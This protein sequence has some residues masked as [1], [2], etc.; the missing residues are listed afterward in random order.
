[1]KLKNVT[2]RT[3]IYVLSASLILPQW[4]MHAQ[5]APADDFKTSFFDLF[6]EDSDSKNKDQNKDGKTDSTKKDD[7]G[8]F[9]T[10]PNLGGG[11]NNG[12]TKTGTP[13]N[14][15]GNRQGNNNSS[16][17]SGNTMKSAKLAAPYNCPLFENRPHKE[18]IDAITQLSTA[19]NVSPECENNNSVKSIEENAKALKD[20]MTALSGTLDADPA[21]FTATGFDANVTAALTA[22]NNLG[23]ILN[24]NAFLNSSCGRQAMSSGKALLAFNDM[25]NGFA[26]Y[27]LFA[28]AAN[29]ALAPALPFV[30]GGTVVTTGISV[31]SKM[32]DQKTLDMVKPEHRDAVL[33]NT[34]QYV[35]VAK[36]VRF[37]QLAQSGKIEKISQELEQKIT[38]YK[39][40]FSRPSTELTS[41]LAYRQ[42]ASVSFSNMDKQV[43]DDKT[44]LAAVNAQL[45]ANSDDLMVCTMARELVNWAQDGK[46]FPSSAFNN[47][48]QV[49]MQGDRP[50][51]L[52]SVTLKSLNAASMKRIVEAADLAPTDETALK[53]CAQAGKTWITGIN[54][55]VMLTEKTLI[56]NKVALENELAQ[57]LEYRQFMTQYTK[58]Q[59][60]Q[61]TIKRV[62]KAMENLAKDTAIIDR[63]ELAQR[64]TLLKNALFGT[65]G[66]AWGAP[67]VL[68]WI[69]H[70]KTM[71]ERAISGF[72]TSFD[73]VAAG[74]YSLTSSGKTN[75]IQ[76]SPRGTAEINPTQMANDQAVS[77]T[78]A[79]ITLAQ[80]PLGSRENELACQT[81]ESAWLD[82][83]ASWD[84]LG[85]IEAFCSM[86]DPVLDA[87]MDTDVIKACRGIV[88]L[89][90]QVQARSLVNEAK[91]TLV[92]KGFAAQANL[93]NQKM[94]ELRCP[95]PAVSV[96]ND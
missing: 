5:A 16:T 73:A 87:K 52:Q 85:A 21:T 90:G 49:A 68:A 23:N 36:K 59:K 92:R 24:N 96:M 56:E 29:A 1:M 43:K 75:G 60:E 44:D 76:R 65:K 30:I 3:A 70:T 18:L 63:S 40:S 33:A 77:K 69:N 93:V 74:S 17:N 58:I 27:A 89:N 28:V 50:L 62:E 41:L 25:V 80:L 86:I 94:K 53:T 26:P 83:S 82:Y 20:T 22:V 71:Q 8:L 31:M 64:M 6:P 46:T 4:P 35:N 95:V 2:H 84:H 72:L 91:Q 47:L 51:K 57:N 19:V 42:K 48:E 10:T 14:A 38:L 13:G 55:A 79:S 15:T 12:G 66:F 7:T 88:A 61:E 45:K 37:M 32:I 81:L 67:P 11:N 34:C 39:T 78:L 9:P 54:Q